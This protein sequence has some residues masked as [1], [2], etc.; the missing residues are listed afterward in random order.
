MALKSSAWAASRTGATWSQPMIIWRKHAQTQGVKVFCVSSQNN[1][2]VLDDNKCSLPIWSTLPKRWPLKRVQKYLKQVTFLSFGPR[3]IA[4]MRAVTKQ[5]Q[6]I[7][8]GG[9]KFML[10]WGADSEKE[11]HIIGKTG[12][13][14]KILQN[15]LSTARI[16]I[17]K[18]HKAAK[19]PFYCTPSRGLLIPWH[20]SVG[21]LAHH[22][23]QRAS[24]KV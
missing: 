1:C 17:A 21:L 4:Q 15:S 10:K 6:Q 19:G 8:Q 5:R 13:P 18:F 12:V 24:L 3:I 2:V 11:S 14:G 7:K 23:Q 20:Q 16:Q 9:R 22:P